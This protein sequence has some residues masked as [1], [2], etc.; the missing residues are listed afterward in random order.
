MLLSSEDIRRAN[1]FSWPRGERPDVHYGQQE[2]KQTRLEGSADSTPV[3][4]SSKRDQL[5][6]FTLSI[7][8]I[9]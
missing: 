2:D 6:R 8:I 3:H 9:I 5:V 4:R 1:T 7:I